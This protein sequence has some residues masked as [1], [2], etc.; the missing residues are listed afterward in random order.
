MDEEKEYFMNLYVGGKFFRDLYMQYVGGCSDCA[1]EGVAENVV[2]VVGLD[3]IGDIAEQ[4]GEGGIDVTIGGGGEGVHEFEN[5]NED[6]EESDNRR[7]KVKKLV[8]EENDSGFIRNDN[9]FHDEEVNEGGNN[10]VVEDVGGNDTDYYDSDDHG[11]L[12]RSD[13]DE[14]EESARRRGKY[15]I[16]NPNTESP[17][18]YLGMISYKCIASKR[19]P[20]RIYVSTNKM[21]GSL[22]FK[23]FIDEHNFPVSFSNE[24]VIAKWKQT[25]DWM[26]DLATPSSMTNRR[27]WELCGIPYPHAC[28]AIW[29]TG[30]DPDK[31][32]HSYYHKDTY[33][34][35]YKYALQPINGP[36]DWNKSEID[37]V[38]PSV[39]RD[40]PGRPKK[41]RKKQKDEPKK[42]K[43]QHISMIGLIMTCKNCGGQLQTRSSIS[44]GILR[45]YQKS[46]T[47][48]PKN[49][50][51]SEDPIG[52]QES[53]SPKKKK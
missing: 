15:P 23:T 51:G 17:H 38:L 10:G 29:H 18:F 21:V 12:I 13:D 42:V 25:W 50:R 53:I 48:A 2:D 49:R 22:Q 8:D 16:Y 6:D 32:L 45:Q 39:D 30:R 3:D 5:T 40:M 28:C 19:C 46:G 7:I 1:T 4:G 31:F 20:W 35:A 34:K 52:T 33:N 37:P 47:S 44:I 26:M 27:R 43:P 41:N 36:H 14:H 11:S 9:E 24:M